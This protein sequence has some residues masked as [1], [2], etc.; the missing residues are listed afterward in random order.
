MNL[1]FMVTAAIGAGWWAGRRSVE[2]QIESRFTDL[3]RRLR[4]ELQIGRAPSEAPLP[5]ASSSAAPT[6]ASQPSAAVA[7][8]AAEEVTPETLAIISA[9]T[10]AYLGKRARIRRV[11]RVSAPGFNPWSQQGR[12]YRQGSHNLGPLHRGE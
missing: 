3:E 8:S 12:V 10:A 5:P 4:N 11:R 6:P 9:V 1:L 2:Q 7:E